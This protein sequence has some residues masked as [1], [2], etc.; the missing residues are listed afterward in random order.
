VSQHNPEDFCF[1]RESL[2]GVTLST[3][4]HSLDVGFLL[5]RGKAKI[6]NWISQQEEV[7]REKSRAKEKV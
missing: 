5:G 2:F 3:F 1:C 6:S 7:H 4:L